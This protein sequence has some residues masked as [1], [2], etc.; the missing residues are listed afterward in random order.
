[1]EKL[2]CTVKEALAALSLGHTK[3][4]ELVRAGDIDIVKIG[5]RTLVKVASLLRIVEGDSLSTNQ[6]TTKARIGA[7]GGAQE[8][9]R[10]PSKPHQTLQKHRPRPSAAI[11]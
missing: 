8:R 10:T 2:T 7:D 4:Y 9:M 3:F 5:T 1:M 11:R 6:S